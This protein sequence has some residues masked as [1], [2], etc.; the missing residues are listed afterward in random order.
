LRYATQQELA[1]AMGVNQAT[2][3]RMLKVADAQGLTT[4]RALKA[5]LAD[6]KALRTK[7]EQAQPE[8]AEDEPEDSALDI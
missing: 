4:E 1:D 3:S 2:I 7:I 5:K 6:A 8:E